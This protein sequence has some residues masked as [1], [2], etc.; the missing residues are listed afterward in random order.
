MTRLISMW[1]R[2]KINL[3]LS[4]CVRFENPQGILGEH[5][6][7]NAGAKEDDDDSP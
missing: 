4:A 5:T 2:K 6:N 3:N 7:I 1:K